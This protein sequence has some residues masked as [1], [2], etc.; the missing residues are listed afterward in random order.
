MRTILFIAVV[1]L[2][3]CDQLAIGE[4]DNA[5][6]DPASTAIPTSNATDRRIQWT[7][8]HSGISLWSTGVVSFA[9]D[10]AKPI[11]VVHVRV[12]LL[13]KL[14]TLRGSV[15]TASLGTPGHPGVH[16]L[17]VN[18][19]VDNLPVVML[20]ANSTQVLDLFFRLPEQTGSLLMFEWSLKGPAGPIVVGAMLHVDTDARTDRP[21]LTGSRWWFDPHY[22]WPAFRHQDGII[23]SRPPRNAT[24]T[25]RIEVIDDASDVNDVN[26]CD[27]W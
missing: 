12:G 8:P 9:P 4:T 5:T 23:T 7:T 3:A 1:S 26:P 19:G 24:V 22:P 10:D 15:T 21:S 27:E 14:G 13:S 18:A 6:T 2:T 16:P 20:D 17:A 25:A 11:D